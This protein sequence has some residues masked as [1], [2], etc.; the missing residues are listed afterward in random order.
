[1]SIPAISR[2]DTTSSAGLEILAPGPS[3]TI[4]DLGRAGLARFGV[5]ASGAADRAAFLLANRLVGNEEHAAGLETTYGGLAFRALRPLVVAVTGAPVSLFLDT[6]A[7]GLNCQLYLPAGGVLRLGSPHTGVRSYVAIR[8]GIDVPPVLGSRSTDLLAGIGPPIPVKTSILPVG[9]ATRPYPVVDMAPVAALRSEDIQLRIVLGPRDDWFADRAIEH[10]LTKDFEVTAD[11]NRVG[12]RLRGPELPRRRHG[13]LLS[14][15][16]V[17]GSLQV[18]TNGRLTL[19]LADHPITGGYPVIA[20]VVSPDVG[21]AA[22]A[23]PGQKIRFRLARR[24]S[25]PG[26]TPNRA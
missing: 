20:V 5:G 3:T 24:P 26:V 21:A 22:Q 19:F 4:Q 10:L 25:R 13:E 11:S 18:P 8:G 16:T 15:G 2:P 1:M 23:R 9:G 17:P 14:E 6:R 12:I 7:E